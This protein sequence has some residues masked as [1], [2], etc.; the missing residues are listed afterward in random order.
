MT[1]A[2]N[3]FELKTIGHATLI[4]SEN[5]VPIVATDPW[6]SGS[7]Y[8][9]SWWL[10]QDP[11]PE[12]IDLVRRAK[13][14]YVTHS[15]PDHFHWPSLRL[16]GPHTVLNPTFPDYPIPAFLEAHGYESPRL[17]PWKWYSLTANVRVASVPM[18]FDDSVLVVE[19]PRTVIVNVNDSAA[20]NGM[21]KRI[22]EQLIDPTK[23][24]VV[25][26]SYSPA[27]SAAVTYVDN[28]RAPLKSKKD[29]AEVALNIATRLGARYF[30]PFA[31][32]AFLG[33]SDSK[34]ANEHKVTYEDLA[35]HWGA[36]PIVLC[37]PF[38]TMDLNTHEFTSSYNPEHRA[39][40]AAQAAKVTEEESGEAGFT[41][42]PEGDHKLKAYL[43]EI[44]FLRML[45]RRGIGWRLTSSKRELFYNSRRRE[46]EHGIPED[47]D[48]VISIPDKVLFGALENGILT[49]LGITLFVRVDTKV[50]LKLTYLAFLLMGVRDYGH[51][52]KLTNFLKFGMFY[53][54]YVFPRL[55]IVWPSNAPGEGDRSL[56]EAALTPR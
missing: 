37:K 5:G 17:E 56:A 52:K 10:D 44:Y 9:R 18:P 45:F 29:F 38:V 50:N 30:V 54:P 8:W 55:W 1:T 13:Y 2:G 33:R 6:L 26:K 32:Q 46:I 24:V 35:Q 25:L 41:W 40:S 7:S 21:L 11:T 12:E 22:R 36:S 51:F 16:V 39:L 14:L 28:Q 42:P 53:M 49:D 4:V 15:H 3:A 20:S 43:D 48:F 34:W 19:T 31:S 27:S 47:H 23:T